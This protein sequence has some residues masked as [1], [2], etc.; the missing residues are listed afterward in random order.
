MTALTGPQVYVLD[1]ISN[2]RAMKR[3]R[4]AAI[5]GAGGA[6]MRSSRK[7]KTTVLCW[8]ETPALPYSLA[9]FKVDSPTPERVMTFPDHESQEA[10]ALF[11]L[12]KHVIPLR[13][14]LDKDLVKARYLLDRSRRPHLPGFYGVKRKTD[15]VTSTTVYHWRE[16]TP[17]ERYS[18]VLFYGE[19]PKPRDR[20]SG[21]TYRQLRD[22]EHKCFEERRQID[23]L[24]R[25]PKV[26]QPKIKALKSLVDRRLT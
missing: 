20:W 5:P 17:E 15:F 16:K 4:I 1:F 13:K 9:I 23:F 10:M 6:K 7:A 14:K 25:N 26:L 22:L 11:V 12:W 2:Q 24:E 8:Q 21:L 18:L 19:S 3:Q